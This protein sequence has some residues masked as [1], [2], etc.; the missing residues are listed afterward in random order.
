[1]IYIGIYVLMAAGSLFAVYRCTTRENTNGWQRADSKKA[2]SFLLYAFLMAF[3]F[4]LLKAVDMVP[5]LPD[6]SYT[7]WIGQMTS[8]GLLWKTIWLVHSFV[9]AYGLVYQQKGSFVVRT[10]LCTI[11]LYAGMLYTLSC[12]EH[13]YICVPEAPVL[14]RLLF[15]A[16]IP[17][18]Y[19]FLILMEQGIYYVL[20]YGQG[21]MTKL[22]EYCHHV[23]LKNMGMIGILLASPIFSLILCEMASNIGYDSVIKKYIFIEVVVMV[24]LELFF[25]ML[26]WKSYRG[27]ILLYIFSWSLG[28]INHYLVML[29]GTPFTFSDLTSIMTAKNVVSEYSIVPDDAVFFTFLLMLL[30]TAVT[31]SMR[32]YSFSFRNRRSYYFR[33]TAVLAVTIAL[34]ISWIG[35]ADWTKLYG[36]SLGWWEPIWQYRSYGLVNAFIESGKDL[37]VKKPEGYSAQAVKDALSSYT[38][39]TKTETVQP[40]IIGIMNESFADLSVLGPLSCTDTDLA[41]YKSLKDDP[42]MIEYGYDYCSIFGGGTAN[43]EFEALSGDSSAFLGGTLPYNIYNFSNISTYPS[44]LKEDGYLTMAMHPNSP[45]NYKR[46]AVYQEMNFD[47]FLSLEDYAGSDTIRGLVSDSGDYARLIAAYEENQKA[48]QPQYIF[49]VT[50]QNHGQY[51]LEEMDEDIALSDVDDA[52]QEYDDLVCYETVLHQSDQALEELLDYFASVDEPVIIYF[53]GDHLPG[54]NEGFLN[55]ITAAGGDGQTSDLTAG[56]K[57]FAVPYFIWANYE[58]AG[59]SE[60]LYV[61]DGMNITSPQYLS[62]SVAAYS[63]QGNT[64]YYQYLFDLRNQIPAINAFGYMDDTGIWHRFEETDEAVNTYHLIEYNHLY[65]HK[66]NQDLFH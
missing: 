19:P 58:A 22:A 60:Q 61:K 43:T 12:M 14:Q 37:Q 31:L 23:K 28:T 21:W 54:L 46:N 25:T 3:S 48:G 35:Y 30:L 41:Y 38:A 44:L 18:S 13:S 32:G 2:V 40:T 63:G 47:S 57:R 52:Y 36:I 4:L 16:Y 53:F 6:A 10:L 15:H 9:F 17:L 29:R 45:Q 65:D 5:D 42:H 1:M 39:D 34:I 49:N 26:P 59:E 20:I 50:M 7:K 24:L 11:L 64:P 27:V 8:F 33:K 62:A 56:M 51:Q 66:N 55:E